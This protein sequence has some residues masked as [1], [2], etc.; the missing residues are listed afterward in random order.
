MMWL[1]D[2]GGVAGTQ[3]QMISGV[4]WAPVVCIFLAMEAKASLV[5]VEEL[6]IEKRPGTGDLAAGT[7]A[8]LALVVTSVAAHSLLAFLYITYAGGLPEAPGHNI[9]SAAAELRGAGFAGLGVFLLVVFVAP[10]AEEALFRGYF[11]GTWRKKMGPRAANFLSS[12]LFA[13]IHLGGHL[14]VFLAG[15]FFA[16]VYER[17]GTLWAPVVAHIANN[18]VAMA[19]LNLGLR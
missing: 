6:G 17:R 7:A 3:L 11:Y 4:V 14:H 15:V 1:A 13:L 16:W 18:A 10:L 9:P 12:M 5:Q 2:Q 19:F 8:Y